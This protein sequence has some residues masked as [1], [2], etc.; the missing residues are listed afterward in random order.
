MTELDELM[1][2]AHSLLRGGG[3][4]TIYDLGNGRLAKV[5]HP[6]LRS[7]YRSNKVKW[8]INHRFSGEFARIIAWPDEAITDH[9]V[10]VGFTMPKLEA[11]PLAELLNNDNTFAVD[12][13]IRA[14]IC[15]NIAAITTHLHREGIVVGD[16]HA[17]NFGYDAGTG[18]VVLYDVDSLQFRDGKRLYLCEVAHDDTRPPELAKIDLSRTEALCEDT[19]NYMLAITVFQL[20]IGAHP[21]A[22]TRAADR[23]SSE[24]GILSRAA[25]EGEFVFETDKSSV[26]VY[27]AAY[28]V[29][30][31][32]H[33]LFKRCFIEGASDPNARPSA[34]EWENILA[35]MAREEMA[36]CQTHGN[37]PAR[38]SSCPFCEAKSPVITTSV[39]KSTPQPIQQKGGKPPGS[40]STSPNDSALG[41]VAKI[42]LGILAVVVGITLL[43][44]I[45][46]FAVL[47]EL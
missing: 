47:D 18:K 20:L 42:V 3:E 1:K 19:D 7:D 33:D 44:V 22:G 2:Q 35:E 8:L 41:I 46:V 4:G 21:Y 40:A 32:A 38:M 29:T 31:P 36:I 5:Y 15:R 26:P 17:S 25:L 12:W 43:P 39:C 13:K 37:Y 16:L 10:I 11:N 14:T 9:G 28:E 6:A 45:L 23:A 24:S 30:S 27:A 34:L